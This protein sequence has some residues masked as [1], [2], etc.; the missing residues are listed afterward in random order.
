MASSRKRTPGAAPDSGPDSD[1]TTQRSGSRTLRFPVE[2]IEEALRRVRAGERAAQADLMKVLILPVQTGVVRALLGASRV[3]VEDGVQ[4]VLLRLMEDGAR[5]LQGW[6]PRRGMGYVTRA[7]YNFVVSLRRGQSK[8]ETW[9]EDLL[10]RLPHDGESAEL[11]LAEAELDDAVFAELEKD[12]TPHEREV[13]DLFLD[14]AS[15]REIGEALKMSDNAVYVVRHRIVQ[16][17]Q[18]I[19]RRLGGP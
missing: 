7:A 14:G 3:D 4:E 12:L 19:R 10:D 2:F 5:R 13:L 1:W 6:D 11:A 9:P 8:L 17:A 18:A 15:T 16:K